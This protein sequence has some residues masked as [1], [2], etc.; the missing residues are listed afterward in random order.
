MSKRFISIWFPYLTTDWHV[1]KQPFLKDKPFVLKAIVRNRVVITAAN[2]LAL[3]QGIRKNMVLAD[4]KALYPSL[5]VID[6]KPTLTTQLPDRIA[7]WCIRF[8]PSAA[9]DYPNGII[10]DATGCTHLWGSEE[11]YLKDI[12][13]RLSQR[14]YTVRAAMADTIGCAWAVARYG[15]QMIVEKGA[16]VETLLPL[17]ITALRLSEE[18]ISVLQKLG[19]RQIKDV[20]SIPHTSLRRRFGTTLLQRLR[21]AIGEEEEVI[22]PVYPIEPYN[23]RLPCIEPIKT[24]VG[25]EIALQH[26]LTNLCSR[27]CKEGKG[28]RTAIF[29]AYRMDGGTSGIEISTN[30]PSQNAEHLFQLFSIK[31]STIEPKE[32]IEL[33]LLEATVVEEAVVKQEGLWQTNS[34]SLDTQV[35]DLMDRYAARFGQDAV[36][37]FLPTEHYW[38]ERSFKGTSIL[39]EEPTTD[40]KLDRPRPLQVLT[41]PEVVDV[42]APIPDY[43]PMSFRYR[44]QLH[45]I[46]KADGPE[47]IE[48]EWWIQEGEHRDYYAVEDEE[49]R[50]YWLFR[51]G[52]YNE[53]T[54]PKWF[55]HG[56]FA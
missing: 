32:G 33:F 47:R 9:A 23:E 56:F 5:H 18:T 41:P 6:D 53:T 36:Q 55:L 50:R 22:V 12:T 15:N 48:Q 14:G 52:H 1:R 37:R 7:E 4:A 44:D 21:Q 29:R 19:L 20:I 10:L 11:A 45:K 35:L 42:T 27:L 24:R 46:V 25:I 39:T 34:S 2:S 8:T 13:S 28:L 17:P 31:I 30:Q 3:S 49:G 16:Q 26:L 54:S 43:P 38:P 51:S 40:W